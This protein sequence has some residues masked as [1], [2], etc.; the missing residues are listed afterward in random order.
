MENCIREVRAWMKEDMLWLNK[1]KTEFILIGS[2]KQLAKVTINSIK[3]GDADIATVSSARN[4]GAW[5]N[6]YMGMAT[7]IS[8]TCSSA[9]YYLYNIRHIRKY[10]SKEHTEQ[11][12]H[13]F[14]TSRL[15]YCNSLLYGI[16]EYQIKKLQRIMNASARLIYCAPKFCHITPILKELHWLPVRARIEF[17]LLL[18]TYEV[19]KGLALKYLSELISVL[20][21]IS[22]SPSITCAVIITVFY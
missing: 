8:K 6:S 9:F 4:L 21:S 5:F 11:L 16:A 10:L 18:I 12:I 17:K 15:D 20:P 19:V 1:S 13:A 2:R 7:H 3:V 14:I 22:L